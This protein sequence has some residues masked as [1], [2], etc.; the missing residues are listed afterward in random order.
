[1][2]PHDWE[3]RALH[4]LGL[5][6][7]VMFTAWLGIATRSV[8]SLAS[9]WPANAVLLG[10]FILQPRLARPAGWLAALLGFV[11]ADLLMGSDLWL[12][13]RL[14]LVNLVFVAGAL[15]LVRAVPPRWRSLR[16]LESLWT[17]TL[18]CLI[19]SC[20]SAVAAVLLA[21]W[22]EPTFFTG[23]WEAAAS[24][25]SADVM[26]A[27]LVLPVML[28]APAFFS[29]LARGGHSRRQ[30]DLWQ[31]VPAVALLASLMV[32]A[33]VG[34]PGSLAVVVLALLWCALS[35]PL[36]ITALLN[37]LTCVWFLVAVSFDLFPFLD[38]GP[39]SIRITVLRLCVAAFALLPLWTVG[40][41]QARAQRACHAAD[42]GLPVGV[43][44]RERLF[45]RAAALM[46]RK[47]RRPVAV[48]MVGPQGSTEASDLLHAMGIVRQ[49][50][51]RT[52]LVGQLHG[53]HFIL[54]VRGISRSTAEAIAERVRGALARSGCEVFR[55][56]LTWYPQPPAEP[57]DELFA[58]AEQAWREECEK[59]RK[60]Q[61]RR[62]EGSGLSAV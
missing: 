46:R 56:G 55:V 4:T 31:F 53:Q 18:I 49:V 62:R 22:L 37:L 8:G 20:C 58:T 6:L 33:G 2:A 32:C 19:A 44:N 26:N 5:A 9:V 42:G 24:W 25:F 59:A 3:T 21:H 57:L 29:H 45:V 41:G 28:S 38:V 36:F 7:L 10:I 16:R 11:A 23:A 48:M 43:L 30:D 50:L 35:Y 39:D 61:P 13:L 1:M 54:V 47:L 52:D 27:V 51:R 60:Q 14:T 15:L 17:Y 40:L 34:G 12:T